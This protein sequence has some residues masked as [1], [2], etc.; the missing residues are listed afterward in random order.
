MPRARIL[1][2][3][4]MAGQHRLVAAGKGIHGLIAQT[5][6]SNG[7][8][9]RLLGKFDRVTGPGY[10]M[11]DNLPVTAPH[12]LVVRRCHMEPFYRIEATN[13]RW[14]W[15]IAEQPFTPSPGA[16]WFLKYWQD[17]LFKG[18]TIANGGYIFMPLQGKLSERRSFQS[19]SP[20]QMIATTLQA[21]PERN[22]LAT[23]HPNE[24]CSAD[25]RAALQGFGPRFQLLDQPSLPLLA[26]CDYVVT[27]NSAMAFTG[28]FARKPAVL[29]ANIDFYHIAGSVPRMGV[30][31]AFQ[32]VTNPQP[33]ASYLH[34]FLRDNAISA[35]SQDAASR[36]LTR[37]RRHSWPI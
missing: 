28:Y 26:G 13:D 25:E 24:T 1:N 37:L 32:A 36:I 16:E 34:W 3:Y 5:V 12:C 4:T 27:E 31:A 21:D 29:F 33:F 7:W 22:I 9:L 2:L 23:L 6:Q 18:Q 14:L 10:H 8:N 17:R 35:W 15:D 30:A 19:Q 20:L 11:V